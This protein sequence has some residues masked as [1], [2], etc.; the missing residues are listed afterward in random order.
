MRG[1]FQTVRSRLALLLLVGCIPVLALGARSAWTRYQDAEDAIL[2]EVGLLME[3]LRTR[4]QAAIEGAGQLMAGL[5][6]VPQL[7]AGPPEACDRALAALLELQRDRY[8]NFG[9]HDSEGLRRCSA[10]PAPRGGALPAT[11]PFRRAITEG[12]LV[13][14]PLVI[15]PQSLAPVLVAVVPMA[16]PGGPAGVLVTGILQT[17]LAAQAGNVLQPG[18]GWVW[19]LPPNS[20]EPVSPQ[21]S[22]DERLPQDLLLQRLR[23]VRS[24]VSF[25]VDR[26]GQAMAYAVRELEDGFSLLVGLPAADGLRQAQ[27]AMLSRAGELALLLTIALGAIMVGGNVAVVSPLR[28]LRAAML[29]WRGGGH[30]SMPDMGAAPIEVRETADAFS[31]AVAAL[32]QRETELQQSLIQRDLLMTEIHHRVKN[33][34][35]VVASLLNLQSGRIRQSE[36]RAEFAVARDRV[37]ALATLHRHLYVGGQFDRVRL[38]DFINEMVEQLF[39]A[40]GEQAGSRIRLVVDVA[41]VT[42]TADQAVPLALIITECITNALKYAFPDGRV[43]TIGVHARGGASGRLIVSIS[44]DGVGSAADRTAGSDGLGARLMEGF[45]KQLGARL[46]VTADPGTTVTVDLPLL[47]QAPPAAN[48]NAAP[49][50]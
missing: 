9:V 3:A 39:S 27:L 12:R 19:L 13:I 4:H 8:S 41:D 18:R 50:A 40:F 36:A 21:A 16:F 35:Q 23:G 43:G 5:S 37:R 22:P 24:E 26:T 2:M 10:L 34:L 14:G 46:T 33:N 28:R 38:S 31:G 20:A 29:G 47:A 15:G 44:D 42:L 32:A 48:A 30:F 17:H 49:A 6:Q 45:A 1:W 25:G 7:T 11:V